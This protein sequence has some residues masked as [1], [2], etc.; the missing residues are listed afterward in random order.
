MRR[1]GIFVSSLLVL[2]V[3][4]CLVLSPLQAAGEPRR[5]SHGVKVL[6]NATSGQD[7]RFA[8]AFQEVENWIGRKAFPG[9]VLAIGHH[10]KLVALKS[11]GKMDYAPHARDM[12]C[13]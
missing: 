1:P 8:A 3:T 10:G 11:F 7:R 12:R 13:D 4:G 9:A 2:S 6:A 5:P